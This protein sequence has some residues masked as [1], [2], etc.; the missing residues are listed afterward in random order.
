[1]IHRLLALLLAACAT[2]MLA[3]GLTLQPTR[4]FDRIVSEG[5]WMQPDVSPDGRTILFDLLGDIYAV[6]STGGAARPVLTGMAFETHPVFA[7]DGKHFAFV[8][9]RS[10][11]TNL[12]IADA[13]G[14]NPRQLSHE[15]SLNVMTSPAWAPDGRSVYVSRMVH[16]VLAFDLWNFSLDG[17]AGTVIAK[18]QPSGGE[19]WDQRHNA[20]GAVASPDGRYLYYAVKTGHTWTEKDLPNWSIARRDLRT[21]EETTIITGQA[22]MHPALSH[23][24]RL[25]AY[26]SRWKQQT[27]LRLRDLETGEDKWIAFPIDHDGQDQGYYADLTPRFT[28]APGDK[29]IVMSVGGKLRR[30][31]LATSRFT[32]IPFTAHIQLG[33]GPLTRVSQKDETGPVHARIIQDPRQ[34][35]DGRRLA[36]SALGH[37]YVQDLAGGAPRALRDA[38]AQ[39]FQP[40]WSPDGRTIAFVTWTA[41]AGGALWTMPAVGG[42]PR[43]LTSAPAFFTEPVWSPDG[44]TIAALRASH[45]DR[46][47]SP[48]EIQPDRPT[49]IVTLPVS[50]G[51]ATLV[52]HAGSARSL[53]FAGDR[54]RY[55]GDGAV[56][57]IRRDGSDRQ[58]ELVVLA[59]SPSQYVGVP[60]PVE[61]VRLDAG[62]T[63]ALAKTAAELYLIDVPARNGATAPVIDLAAPAGRRMKLTRIG[64]DYFDWSGDTITWSLGA[65]YCRVALAA[66]ADDAEAEADCRIA[67][68]AVPRDVP[69]GAIVLR[70]AT[71]VTMRGDQVIANA[72]VVV[73][74]DRIAA[75]GPSGTIPIP[76]GASIRMVAD[77]YLL[78][79]F[80]DVHEHSAE[81]RRGIQEL[82]QP[83]FLASLAY[84]VTS[85]L[86]PQ[87]FT[88]DMFVYQDLID[89]GLMIGPRSYS[90]GRGVFR[91]SGIETRQDAIDVLTRYRD[92]YRTRNIKS[93]MVGDRQERQAM[94]EGAAALGMMPTTEGASDLDLD[95][96][97]AIDGFSGNEHA[98]PVTPLHEDVIQLFAQS[99]T[100]FT[101]TLIVLYGG[102]GA[103][104]DRI[105]RERLEDDPKYQA[106]TPRVTITEKLRNRRWIPP[107]EQSYARFAAD[108]LAIQRAGGLVGI[109]SHGEIQGLGY[110]WEMEA[111]ASGGAT[112]REV[113]TAATIGSA[114]VI[115]H[116]A[117][118]G[119]LEPGKYADILILDADPLADIVN[120]RSIAQVMKGGRIYDANTL[121]EI[122]PRDRPLPRLWMA[123]EAPPADVP[124]G[125]PKR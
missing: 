123:D 117:D 115:G 35:P 41:E 64:A 72:D 73:V 68:V 79:G 81:L 49:D 87:A 111:Y 105:V 84:G 23:D 7:P 33:L 90:V 92:F 74:G 29:A 89:A 18:A 17:G 78:P 37:L 119:S 47:R 13:D 44:R 36:F 120:A 118:I 15:T 27:G 71:A 85:S 67:D 16:A 99:R 82:N 3:G 9:D 69:A 108:A 83:N 62:G 101:P 57:S 19:D 51:Q 106:F 65:R 45:Y 56:V 25:L 5:T 102:S 34:S 112:P 2:P 125:L 1:M 39:A 30:L 113:L 6:D 100:S 53:A 63:H 122:W 4:T 91:D 55:Y 97:H 22:A 96:T 124:S 48:S 110:H 98:L 20:L 43:R 86:D 70:G 59:Q 103:L 11:T 77:K 116:A 60:I 80:V 88:P 54:L 26:A 38:P 104:P 8:S 10:G 121:R 114:E 95:L 46:L 28:F 58:R 31:D 107:E 75:I 40:A 32:D 61:E 76:P 14:A 93:Y 42:T 66:A 52:A 109:G 12:W 50:G 21:G 24:G 94:I